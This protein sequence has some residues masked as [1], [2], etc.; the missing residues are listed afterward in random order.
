MIIDAFIN[1]TVKAHNRCHPNI[2]I[3]K[4]CIA[5]RP[6]Y[7]LY[8]EDYDIWGIEE[9]F[10]YRFLYE[11]LSQERIYPNLQLREIEGVQKIGIVI[12]LYPW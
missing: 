8:L 7:F 11:R 5:G 3:Y 10:L 12:D 2:I 9:S 4:E 1:D 6:W